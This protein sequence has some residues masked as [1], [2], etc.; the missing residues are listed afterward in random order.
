MND[1]V[2]VRVRLKHLVERSFVGD[3]DLGELGPLPGDQFD[4]VDDLCGGIVQVVGNDN[5]VASFEQG[6]GREGP[7]VAR[8]SSRPVSALLEAAAGRCDDSYP[9]TR[10]EP[11]DIVS[12]R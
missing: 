5:L 4:A 11:A 8:S 9:V 7:D 3:I 12:M 1:A 2:N 10:T 6:Q